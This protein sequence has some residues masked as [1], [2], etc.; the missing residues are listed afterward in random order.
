MG[1]KKRVLVTG[2][3]GQIG[4][5]VRRHLGDRYELSGLDRVGLGDA[6]GDVPC[7]VADIADLDAIAPA[8]AGVDAVL[9]LG[10]DPSPRASWE[11]TL[12][13]N[14]VGTRNV[15]E[16]ARLAGVRRVVF[17]SS[18]H[19]AGNYPLRQDPYK[20]IYDGRLGE[21]RMPFAPLGADALRPDSYYGVSKA[22]GESLG[23]YF[24]DEYGIS[25]ICLRIGWVMTPD[26][27]RFSPAALS[28]WLSHRDAAQ[29]IRRS[30]DAPASVGFAVVNGESDNAL[31][32]WDID[33]ARRIL[34]YEPQD[35]AGEEWTPRGDAPSII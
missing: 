13:S 14:I 24:H 31:S 18:N 27:P 10:A 22:F 6:S 34:G 19:V 2:M 28:L 25:V 4:G 30:I 17:A 26:D 15:Y 16:A 35:G 8:F 21:V 32:I 12:S 33:A 1:D 23:S 7:V 29:L 20:A 3:A 5:I 11:S 9:H